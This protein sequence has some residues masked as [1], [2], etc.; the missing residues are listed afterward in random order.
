VFE[1]A[2][3]GTEINSATIS[4]YSAVKDDGTELLVTGDFLLLAFFL[5]L[6][7]FT[8]FLYSF[9]SF[10]ML[11][12]IASVTTLYQVMYFDTT[13]LETMYSTKKERATKTLSC[14]RR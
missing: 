6:T 9:L 1:G 7:F 5:I 10:H 14:F 2:G 8:I 4:T 12:S 3:D 11:R 13:Q